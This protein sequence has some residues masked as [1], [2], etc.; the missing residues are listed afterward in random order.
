[1]CFFKVSKT[2]VM[3]IFVFYYKNG[4]KV[5]TTSVINNFVIKM[6]EIKSALMLLIK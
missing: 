4:S 5:A 3:K 2:K 6:F 1:M